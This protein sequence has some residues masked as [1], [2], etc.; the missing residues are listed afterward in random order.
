MIG[1]TALS[2]FLN[3]LSQL[4][5][6]LNSRLAPILRSVSTLSRKGNRK[7]HTCN[8]LASLDEVDQNRLQAESKSRSNKSALAEQNISCNT[9]RKVRTLH[10]IKCM[11]S[12]NFPYSVANNCQYDTGIIYWDH[13]LI[14]RDF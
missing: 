4:T 13:A 6:L 8:V 1:I 12:A 9:V 7:R 10:I 3:L 14:L 2:F 11:Q 5:K